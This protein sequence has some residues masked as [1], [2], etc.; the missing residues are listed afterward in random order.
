MLG[1]RIQAN[2][3]HFYLV[4]TISI[5]YK[6]CQIKSF[7]TKC[8]AYKYNNFLCSYI[9]SLKKNNN[10]HRIEHASK[11]RLCHEERG[12]ER[13]SVLNSSSNVGKTEKTVFL[14]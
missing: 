1:Y 13:E 2:P 9:H 4:E 3:L 14:S 10:N 11:L 12:S 5:I 7:V 6:N 8:M